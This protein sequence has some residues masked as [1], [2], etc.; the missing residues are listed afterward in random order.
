MIKINKGRIDICTVDVHL[1][2]LKLVLKINL[3]LYN[4]FMP[5]LRE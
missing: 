3:A 4:K 5:D 1:C 2:N